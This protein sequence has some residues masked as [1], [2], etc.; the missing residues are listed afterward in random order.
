MS[1]A[2]R[3]VA[4]LSK[5]EQVLWMSSSL[6]DDFFLKEPQGPKVANRE[7]HQSKSDRADQGRPSRQQKTPNPP[8]GADRKTA[9]LDSSRVDSVAP[10]LKPGDVLRD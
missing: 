1:R 3:G 9:A 7:Q 4:R 8:Q 2:R 5:G 10:P 6:V